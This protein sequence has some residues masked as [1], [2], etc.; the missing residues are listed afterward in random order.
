MALTVIIVINPAFGRPK[1]SYLKAFSS[2]KSD[3]LLSLLR[4]DSIARSVIA[5]RSQVYM[6]AWC[7]SFE[8]TGVTILL[9]LMPPPLSTRSRLL[10]L[11]GE[12]LERSSDTP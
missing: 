1:S 7:V 9:P 2:E 3:F 10:P 8:N 4:I 12:K 11:N 5:I 6:Y